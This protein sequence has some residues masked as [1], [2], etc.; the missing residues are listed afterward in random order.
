MGEPGWAETLRLV[1]KLLFLFLFVYLISTLTNQVINSPII[2]QLS[3]ESN[4]EMNVDVP[5]NETSFL[6]SSSTYL[7]KA[8]F[9]LEIKFCFEK[10]DNDDIDAIPFVQCATDFGAQCSQFITTLQGPKETENNKQCLLFSAPLSFKLGQTSERLFNNGSFL[11]FEY[12]YKKNGSIPIKNDV[13]T[14]SSQLQVQ[15]YNKLRVQTVGDS[16][17]SGYDTEEND[18]SSYGLVEEGHYKFATSKG[19]MIKNSYQLKFGFTSTI[20]F[21]L[22]KRVTLNSGVWNYAGIAS[23]VSTKYEIDTAE[24]PEYFSTV[25]DPSS[26]A[27]QPLGSLRVVPLTCQTKVLREQKAFAF[28]NA[29]GIFGGLFGLLFSLQSCLFG[30]RPRSPWGYMHRWSFGQLRSSLMRGLQVNFFQNNVAF[31]N[32]QRTPSPSIYQ[33]NQFSKFIIPNTIDHQKESTNIN[34]DQIMSKS[35]VHPLTIQTKNLHNNASYLLP[36]SPTLSIPL[37]NGDDKELRMTLIEDKIHMLERLFQ[38]YYIDDE[39][40]RSLDYAIQSDSSSSSSASS[41]LAGGQR[42][43]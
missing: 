27:P 14:G 23:S 18:G 20:N 41:S 28:I 17:H 2:D 10:N 39:I 21:E 34:I 42:H 5:G 26:G 43:K 1:L 40:F 16:Y 35:T 22:I 36:T 38:A 8:N 19:R 25:Y 3:F 32:V 31:A 7:L 33:Q 15:I 11:K 4:P 24:T 12:Y 9:V 29:M 37:A 6:Y 30:Y 13:D